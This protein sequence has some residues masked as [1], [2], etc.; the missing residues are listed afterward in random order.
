MERGVKERT[1]LSNWWN[2]TNQQNLS[3]KAS[4]KLGT[5]IK[6][7]FRTPEIAERHRKME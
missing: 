6:N 5:I 4:I 1:G 3:P 7:N 2:E